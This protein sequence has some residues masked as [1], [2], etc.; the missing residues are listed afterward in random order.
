MQLCR[1]CHALPQL[2]ACKGNVAAQYHRILCVCLLSGEIIQLC[3][4]PGRYGSDL[5][6]GVD[7][8]GHL[9][10][11]VVIFHHHV[12]GRRTVFRLLLSHILGQ[13]LVLKAKP[14]QVDLV[15]GI[16]KGKD[17]RPR[18]AEVLPDL[19]HG[20]PRRD[21][22]F[23]VFRCKRR[24]QQEQKA[25]TEQRRHDLPLHIHRSFSVFMHTVL[26]RRQSPPAPSPRR[27]CLPRCRHH[28]AHGGRR[29][30]YKARHTFPAPCAAPGPAASN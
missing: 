22:G 21:I 13:G 26:P 5:F 23:A 17:P 14:Q 16:A 27:R 24:R 20:S 10:A 7:L 30:P 4:C 19:P 6:I 9:P 18:D 3:R 11:G 28:G 15:I 29:F 1:R 2:S 8:V 25:G 12:Q